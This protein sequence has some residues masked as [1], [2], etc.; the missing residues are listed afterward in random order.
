MFSLTQLDILHKVFLLEN[1]TREGRSAS[2][3]QS[4]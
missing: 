2:H 3:S 4:L 1:G